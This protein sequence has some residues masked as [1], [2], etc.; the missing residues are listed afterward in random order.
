MPKVAVYNIRGEQVEELE[1]SDHIFGAEIHESAM[2]QVIIAQLS[3]ARQGTKSTLTRSEVAG[4]G[5]KPWR[6]KGTGRARHGSTRAPQWRHG[7]V[8]FAPKPR[9]FKKSVNKKVRRLAMYSALS[10]KVAEQQFIVVDALEMEAKTKNM[11]RALDA[12]KAEKK[13]LIVTSEPNTNV[14]LA[15]R[16]IPGVNT[17]VVNTI[18]VYDLMNHDT[19]V[20]TKEAVARIEEVYAE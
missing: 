3:N 7:G 11:V 1:L 10:S 8:V 17:T 5:R 13:A 16:N 4:G 12:L 14:I 15:S 18:N 2:H 19:C 9:L 20:I 6:Q